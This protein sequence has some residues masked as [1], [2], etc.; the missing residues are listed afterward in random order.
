MRD[1]KKRSRNFLFIVSN[2]EKKHKVITYVSLLFL[3]V[4]TY[5][6]KNRKS[7]NKN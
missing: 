6:F 4:S 1:I 3:T 5:F 7:K 2:L